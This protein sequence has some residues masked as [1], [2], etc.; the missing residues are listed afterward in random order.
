MLALFG[1]KDKAYLEAYQ[2][3]F[4]DL[5]F[6]IEPPVF[7]LYTQILQSVPVAPAAA[8]LLAV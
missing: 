4:Q 3:H 1:D 2:M 5:A 8:A 7:M 6:F